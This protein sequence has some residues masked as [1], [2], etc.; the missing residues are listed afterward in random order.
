MSVSGL[1]SPGFPLVTTGPLITVVMDSPSKSVT[2]RAKLDWAVELL[3]AF[4]YLLLIGL[5]FSPC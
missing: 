1:K 4:P 2:V 5:V 3:K